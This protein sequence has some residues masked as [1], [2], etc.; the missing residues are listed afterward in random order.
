MTAFPHR[1]WLSRWVVSCWLSKSTTPQRHLLQRG[2]PQR[3]IPTEGNPPAEL[4]PQRSG[5]S[6]TPLASTGG[7]PTPDSYG[8]KPSCRTG[9]ATQ[10]LLPTPY[11]LLLIYC[12]VGCHLLHKISVHISQQKLRI[13]HNFLMKPDGGR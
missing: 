1:F 6:P 12:S 11:S 3:Q 4:A 5:S 9:S 8:G 10:W 13:F 7:T 2:E